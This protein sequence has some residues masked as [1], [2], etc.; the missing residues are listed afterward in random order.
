M[1]E[2][3]T[4]I[5]KQHLGIGRTLAVLDLGATLVCGAALLALSTTALPLA[6]GA[7]AVAVGAVRS[8]DVIKGWK[9]PETFV[10]AKTET[11]VTSTD[12]QGRKVVTNTEERRFG[13]TWGVIGAIAK[14]G[15][16]L[17]LLG[18]LAA[19]GGLVGAG[20]AAIAGTMVVVGGVGA[21]IGLPAVIIGV[22][23]LAFAI[24][25]KAGT[26]IFT[27]GKKSKKEAAE[28]A[29]FASKFKPAN[30]KAAFNRFGHRMMQPHKPILSMSL[31]SST[32]TTYKYN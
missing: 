1:A 12:A 13:K 29:P 17:G 16:G 23:L 28:R 2:E 30:I 7:A 15:A 25:L 24:G 5:T 22:P 18:S 9:K 10:L 4:Q 32:S 27:I 31:S 26:G 21:V 3:S 8:F 6:F 14:G 19:T 11:E 20:L